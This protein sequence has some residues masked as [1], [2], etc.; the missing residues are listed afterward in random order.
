MGLR[1]MMF[2][3]VGFGWGGGCLFS[4]SVCLE[5]LG[6]GFGLDCLFGGFVVDF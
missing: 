3:F 1:L 6:F 4:L 2:L 5:W